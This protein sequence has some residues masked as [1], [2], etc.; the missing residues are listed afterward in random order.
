MLE[1]EKILD[2]KWL[3]IYKKEIN[4]VW[5]QVVELNTNLFILEKIAKFNFNLFESG[6]NTFWIFVGDALFE[7]CIMCAWRIAVDTD[8]TSLTANQIKNAVMKHVVDATA[9]K[10]LR[11][12]LRKVDFDK[13]LKEV[14]KRLRDLR[15]KRY[16]HFNKQIVATTTT[17][18][19]QVPSISLQDLKLIRDTLNDL[20]QVLGLGIQFMFLP[21]DYD[22]TVKHPIDTDPRPDIVRILDDI[23]LKSHI[24]RM[25]EK[26]PQFWK[27]LKKTLSEQVI[28]EISEYRQKFGLPKI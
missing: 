12:Q 3:E 23:A 11:S 28:N 16:G 27:H 26:E 9:L 10:Q 21:L 5:L 19:G 8:G 15:H 20:M 13:K 25:P 17:K 18:G 1:A 22:P 7:S 4:A 14:G 2:P 24:L 6:T